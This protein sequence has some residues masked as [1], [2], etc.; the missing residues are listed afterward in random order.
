MPTTYIIGADGKIVI[1]SRE[2]KLEDVIT[3]L[4]TK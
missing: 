3:G 1:V 4:L 2:Q